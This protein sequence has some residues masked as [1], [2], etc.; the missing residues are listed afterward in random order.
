[1]IAYIIVAAGVF[2]CANPNVA[3]SKATSSIPLL[4]SVSGVKLLSPSAN[5]AGLCEKVA[6]AMSQELAKPVSLA[7]DTSR[8]SKS[9]GQWIQVYVKFSK[10]NT[11]TA[12]FSHRLNTK[13]KS[14]PP[15][16]IS[17]MDR[18]MDEY[19]IKQLIQEMRRLMKG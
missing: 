5:V 11:V 14:H 2:A 19:M 1:M 7:T 9:T 6:A 4:C 13:V 16:S 10:S 8:M 3:D 17:V 12:T 18:A 15:F